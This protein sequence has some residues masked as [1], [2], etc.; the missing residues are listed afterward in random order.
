MPVAAEVPAF[1]SGAGRLCLDFIRTLRYRGSA[2]AVEELPGLRQLAAWV[3]RFGPP[4]LESTDRAAWPD[5]VGGVPYDE[6][7]RVLREA[8]HLLV[9][10]ARGPEGP[11]GCPAEARDTV[12][13]A[14]RSPVPAPWLDASGGLRFLAADPVLAV[15]ALVARD[16][17]DLAA[18][19]DIDRVRACANS[20]C[21]ALFIDNSRPGRRRWCSMNTCGNLAKKS[22]LRARTGTADTGAVAEEPGR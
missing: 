1:R 13:T 9:A 7:A 15:L 8:V 22:A 21:G 16:A 19:P 10:A 11:A 14:A 18:S 3:E 5:G 6:Q 17:L 2:E 4:G 20:R 12:N